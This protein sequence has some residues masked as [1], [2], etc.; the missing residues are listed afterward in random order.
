MQRLFYIWTKRNISLYQLYITR[1]AFK[2]ADVGTSTSSLLNQKVLH[3]FLLKYYWDNICR[4]RVVHL[5]M[6]DC[7][8]LFTWDRS[9]SLSVFTRGYCVFE[10]GEKKK[11]QT[12]Q[13]FLSVSSRARVL[14]KCLG[15][16]LGPGI[17]R[18]HSST[19]LAPASFFSV[20]MRGT[21]STL[22]LLSP[23]F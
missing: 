16:T 17:L 10:N 8:C 20:E 11:T 23:L 3:K 12:Q 1:I 15:P 18:H 13:R 14:S 7:V 6:V 22:M 21:A 5:V 9:V 19:F 4:K 2:S